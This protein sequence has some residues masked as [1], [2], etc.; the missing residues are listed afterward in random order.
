MSTYRNCKNEF[1]DFDYALPSIEGFTDSSWHNDACPSLSKEIAEGIFV[2]IF[3]DY[4]KKSLREFKDYYKYFVGVTNSDEQ[5][6]ETNSLRE[7]RQWVKNCLFIQEHIANINK[8][9]E[10]NTPHNKM[11]N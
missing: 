10:V 11:P 6:F 5:I 7:L 9:N 2:Q 1:P 8:I 3:C 4:R